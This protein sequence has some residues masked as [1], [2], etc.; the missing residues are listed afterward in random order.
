MR[1]CVLDCSELGLALRLIWRLTKARSGLFS[2][3]IFSALKLILSI[4]WSLALN[5]VE[6]GL[7]L[8]LYVPLCWTWSVAGTQWTDPKPCVS[9]STN[10]WAMSIK[11][12]LD[13]PH[14]M[15]WWPRM[16]WSWLI[17][18][19]CLFT[20]MQSSA[21][22]TVWEAMMSPK[23]KQAPGAPPAQFLCVKHAHQRHG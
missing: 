19:F 3:A 21:W 11:F 5:L 4:L 15:H 1:N 8:L 7:E 22:V 20:S 23:T 12:M 16:L 2:N 13:I 6:R 17:F 9:H 10:F 18:L 14:Y